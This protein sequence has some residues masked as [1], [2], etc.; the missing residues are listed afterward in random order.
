LPALMT[1]EK[2]NHISMRVAFL[3]VSKGRIRLA[4]KKK[5]GLSE[6]LKKVLWGKGK[7]ILKS[8]GRGGSAGKSTASESI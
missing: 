5:K 2:K 3:R 6:G 1:K 4:G 8:L 7:A